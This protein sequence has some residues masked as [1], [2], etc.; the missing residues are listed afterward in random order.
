MTGTRPSQWIDDATGALTMI[1]ERFVGD[2]ADAPVVLP[3]SQSRLEKFDS[4][5]LLIT[6]PMHRRHVP[7]MLGRPVAYDDMETRL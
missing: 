6:S 2:I 1:W 3:T 4:G 5:Q 7:S